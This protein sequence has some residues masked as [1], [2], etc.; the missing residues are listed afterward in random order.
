MNT[1]RRELGEDALT[2]ELRARLEEVREKIDASA[3]RAGRDPAA[4][5]LIAV[6][7]THPADLIARAISAGVTDLGE[8]RVQE[9]EEKIARL[10]GASGAGERGERRARWHLIGHLQSNKARRAVKLFDAVHTV[11]SPALVERLERLCEEEGRAELPVLAQL[12]IAGEATKA[13]ADARELPSIVE[14]A[15]ACTRVRLVGLMTMPPY[16]ED[17]E[18]VRPYFRALRELRDE[19]RARGA[20]AKLEGGTPAS[21]GA[22]ELS[23]GMSHDFRVAVEE[24]ATLVRVGTAIFGERERRD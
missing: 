22:G 14:R 9:A 16:F 3:R 15:A 11:D 6:S 7:K 20:F 4:V 1:A 24:G 12:S 18:R 21:E 19:W 17:A 8:N 2:T 13:G 5:R 10:G 23:M